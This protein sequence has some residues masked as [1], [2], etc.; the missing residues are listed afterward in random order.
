MRKFILGVLKV[1]VF[2]CLLLALMSFS[3]I[4]TVR[5]I[6]ATSK[7]EVP[8]LVGKDVEYATNVLAERHLQL[9]IVERQID[10][11]LQKD[12]IIAQEPEP[13]VKKKK[14]QVVRLVVSGGIET[15]LLPNVIGKSWQQAKRLLRQQK[16]R[17]GNVAYAHSDEIPVDAIIAQTP[18]P[19][20][21]AG[22]GTSVDLLVSRGSYKKVMVMPD[23]VEQDLVYALGVIEKLGLVKG[24]VAYEDYDVR[25]NMVLSHVPRPGA[26]VGEQNMVTL[27]V[28]KGATGRSTH[29]ATN[30]VQYQ[31]LDYTVPPGPF[32]REISV[33]VKNIGG[34][35]E[36][37]REF[38]S[39]GS[40]IGLQI[41]VAGPTV[42]EIFVDGTLDVV[43]RINNE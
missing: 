2:C 43:R 1:L 42:V 37:Y 41:P 26:L 35:V 9:R 3:G 28:S 14:S 40:L 34:I 7:V 32:D 23:L 16:F 38:V 6:L 10:A 19:G 13:G 15:T 21:N 36:I 5:Y 22:I 30:V 17:I 4:A 24:N 27:V 31:P 25:P 8:D 39:P 20:A 12:H 33:I 29:N 11:Q 18:F